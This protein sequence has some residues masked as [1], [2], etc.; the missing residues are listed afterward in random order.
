MGLESIYRLSLI[1][2]MVDNL[3]GPMASVQSSVGNTVSS[4][5]GMQVSF[6]DMVKTGAAMAG[7]G[8]QITDAVLAPVKATFE[9]KRAIGEL[10]SLGVQ[11]LGVVEDAARSFSNTWAGTTAADFI[12]AAYDIKSGIASL[13]DEG[14]AGFTGIASLT[15]K[16]TKATAAEMTSLFAT[17]Y[18]I[19]KKYYGDLSDMEFGE[20]FSAGI[21]DSVRAFKTSG[22]GM[23]EAIS[24]LGASATTAQVPLE[25]Q[26]AIL[27]MLQATMSGSEAGTKYNGFI[28]SAVKGGEELGMSF[29]DANNQL[30]S[31][32]EI[33]DKLR[34]KFGDTIDAAEKMELQKAFG[35]I[36]AVQFIDLMYD[37]ADELQGGILDLYS[38]MGEGISVAERMAN[39]IN[40][41]DA[42]KYV[43]LEQ[44]LQNLKEAVGN[45]LNISGFMDQIGGYM[46]KA[47][48]WIGENQEL[49]SVLMT[50]AL[51][52][53]AFLTVA[54]SGIAVIGGTGLVFTKMIGFIGG[55]IGIVQKIP[56]VI[57]IVIKYGG[58]VGKVLFGLIGTVFKFSA[59]LFACPVTWIVLAIIALIAGLVLLYNKCEWF[60]NAVN[61]VWGAI[62]NGVMAA[63]NIIKGIFGNMMAA[64]EKNGGGLKGITAA[65]LTGISGIWSA[66]FNFIDNLTGGKLSAIRD[67]FREKLDGAKQIAGFVLGA[68]ADTVREKLDNMKAAY[69]Q[70]GGGISG[71]A[72]AAIEGVKG[73]YTAGYSFIDNLTGG[74]LTDIRNKFSEGVESMRNAIAEKFAA[75][76]ESGAKLITTFA[77]GIKSALSAPIEAVR[78]G[79]AKIRE[80]LPFSDAKTGPLSEL[81]L[82]GRKVLDTVTTGINQTVGHPAAA[83]ENALGRI[84]L[85]LPDN[86]VPFP[87]IQNVQRASG[88]GN[89]FSFPTLPEWAGSADAP[90]D[91]PVPQQPIDKINIKEIFRESKET[92]STVKEKGGGVHIGQVTFNLDIK[93]IDDLKKAI[94]LMKEFEEYQNSNGISPGEET[95]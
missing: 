63:W 78:G 77:E 27:G 58:M 30:L 5:Q 72:A 82:S 11:D 19:Y 50:A 80:M 31:L 46:D 8:N 4:L 70:H 56:A 41:T 26:L 93:D 76:R 10:A 6:G 81:T 51:A 2:N 59:A 84:D 62:K 87:Q 90:A 83:V 73:Y 28:R 25:E 12:T 20:M 16:A 92:S 7:V 54:G 3:T 65:I 45:T 38:S 86:V 1:M 85:A 36:R 95:A 49:V 44:K 21:A 37:K 74:K 68:A 67:K 32:P 34:G 33:L 14:V 40:S 71:I 9:T 47:A 42:D 35:D 55:F 39:A 88:S 79:L 91:N 13:S 89:V 94:K 66:G 64:Y 48:V 52:L 53:G 22:S 75:F 15:A 23:A 17:G 43:V 29:M 57:G 24:S 61:A 18:G 60:R 69:E